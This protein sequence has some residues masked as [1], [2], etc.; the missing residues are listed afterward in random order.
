MSSTVKKFVS[1]N[2]VITMTLGL[3]LGVAMLGALSMKAHA[4]EGVEAPAGAAPAKAAA[5]AAVYWS[6]ALAVAGSCW[7]RASPSA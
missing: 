4:G 7:R 6:A 5:P 1:I 2:L 3:I